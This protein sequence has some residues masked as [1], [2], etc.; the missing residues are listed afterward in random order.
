MGSKRQERLKGGRFRQSCISW[1]RLAGPVVGTYVCTL[2]HETARFE[3][4]EIDSDRAVC[5]V[6]LQSACCVAQ[7]AKTTP[8]CNGAS[9]YG[10]F[11]FTSP[12]IDAA[13]ILHQIEHLECVCSVRQKARTQQDA[14]LADFARDRSRRC[15]IVALRTA[16][17]RLVTLSGGATAT[18][19]GSGARFAVT[20][21]FAGCDKRS[22]H[23]AVNTVPV[24]VSIRTSSRGAT[25]L[26][27]LRRVGGSSRSFSVGSLHPIRR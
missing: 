6:S 20:V 4:H 25:V 9:F 14:S 13:N 16:G 8:T 26:T 2:L 15:R 3:E 7:S 23:I 18:A 10:P 11:E 1:R 27:A 24:R 21:F 12:H 5:L 22:I 17:L 19:V